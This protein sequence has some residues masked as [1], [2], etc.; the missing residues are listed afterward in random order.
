ML[1]QGILELLNK[2]TLLNN[3]IFTENICTFNERSEK[4]LNIIRNT[5]SGHTGVTEL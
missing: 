2:L 5:S 1:L 4:E 3:G